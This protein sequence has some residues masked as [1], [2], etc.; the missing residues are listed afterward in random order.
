MGE[1]VIREANN[2][3]KG[4]AS[5]MTSRGNL[6]DVIGSTQPRGLAVAR[7]T[8]IAK[9]GRKRSGPLYVLLRSLLGGNAFKVTAQIH[10]AFRNE[11][12]VGVLD[13]FTA[14]GMMYVFSVYLAKVEKSRSW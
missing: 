5:T 1:V 7:Q 2:L 14:K 12:K 9:V 6:C 10:G 3:G 8:D 4:A 11:A 13:I